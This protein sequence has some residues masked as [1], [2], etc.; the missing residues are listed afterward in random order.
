MTIAG[1][2]RSRIKDQKPDIWLTMMV[3][4]HELNTDGL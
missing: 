2:S 3:I 1:L 4:L